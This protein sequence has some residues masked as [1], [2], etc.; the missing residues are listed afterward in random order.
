MLCLTISLIKGSWADALRFRVHC[1]YVG[2]YF[3]RWDWPPVLSWSSTQFIMETLFWGDCSLIFPTWFRLVV[4][5]RFGGYLFSRF[6]ARGDC[7][8]RCSTWSLLEMFNL[9]I[10]WWRKSG[11]KAWEM[12][13]K[14]KFILRL[15]PLLLVSLLCCGSLLIHCWDYSRHHFGS[16]NVFSRWM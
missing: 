10:Y 1:I 15:R 12:V 3:R 9:L 4:F 16:H 2:H 8:L 6:A 14:V 5:R 11:E 13:P 7:T